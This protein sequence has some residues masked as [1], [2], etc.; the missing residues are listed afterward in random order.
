ML[1]CSPT[2][3]KKAEIFNGID[4]LLKDKQFDQAIVDLNYLL[5]TDSL[6][7]QE[8]RYKLALTFFLRSDYD[9][10]L[11]TLNPLLPSTNKEITEIVI[12]SLISQ[13]DQKSSFLILINSSV[14]DHE[15]QILFQKYFPELNQDR[16]SLQNVYQIEIHCSL[17]GELLFFH[18]RKIECLKCNSE[19]L[20]KFLA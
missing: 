18:R 3:K 4:K 17:C 16:D 11:N 13:G 20:S 2:E 14:N 10:V 1:V 12:Q 7:N 19:I 6:R 8:I 9:Q 15:K 5:R